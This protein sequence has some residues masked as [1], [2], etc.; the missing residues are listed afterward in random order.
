[1]EPMIFRRPWPASAVPPVNGEAMRD[2]CTYDGGNTKLEDTLSA[3]VRPRVP[4]LFRVRSP[5][6][7]TSIAPPES[8]GGDLN[9]TPTL[10][11]F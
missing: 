6:A 7:W 5:T 1:M 9:G 2:R 10:P 4:A 11:A 8:V 3:F